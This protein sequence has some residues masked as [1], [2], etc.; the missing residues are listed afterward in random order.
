MSRPRGEAEDV[1]P[2]RASAAIG[3]SS[4]KVGRVEIFAFRRWRKRDALASRAPAFPAAAGRWPSFGVEPAVLAPE[5]FLD[6]GLAAQDA[7]AAVLQRPAAEIDHV[8]LAGLRLHEVGMAGALQRR[9]GPV[10]R[11][12]NVS[13][14]M[15]LVRPEQVARPRHGDGMVPGRAAFRRQQI[16]EAVAL[17]E[18]RRFGQAQRRA[19]EDSC[20]LA[21]QLLFAR[22]IFLRHDAGE[23]IVAG[24]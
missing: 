24:R 22:R 15:Q 18:M 19:L 7:A 5:H 3:K 6:R 8:G 2:A 12:E 11:A 21:D 16:I 14:G 23:A 4:G 1:P 10:A 20:A 13:V 9:I 17:V